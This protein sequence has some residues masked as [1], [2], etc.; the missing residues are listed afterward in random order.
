MIQADGRFGRLRQ[1]SGPVVDVEF[2]IG[3]LPAIHDALKIE[4]KD[5]PLDLTLEVAQHVGERTVRCVAMS[6]TDGLVRNMPVRHTGQ[7]ILAPVGPE[8]L[9]RIIDVTGRA[10]DDAGPLEAKKYYPIHRPAPSFAE[11]ENATELLETGIKVVD[12][13]QPI[14]K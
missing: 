11:Q 5:P 1:V 10:I 4:R 7:P 8:V 6:T 3:G 13:L 9:G 14:P 2:E 12:L